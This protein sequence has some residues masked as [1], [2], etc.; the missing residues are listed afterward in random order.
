[1]IIS[2]LQ[3]QVESSWLQA[4]N[5]GRGYPIGIK[6]KNQAG[7]LLGLPGRLSHLT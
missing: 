6:Q 3:G 1:M 5:G 2:G 4:E 7:G